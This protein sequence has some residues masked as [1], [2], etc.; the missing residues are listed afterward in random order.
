MDQNISKV[1][2]I[3]E[4]ENEE[5]ENGFIEKKD[6]KKREKL[7]KTYEKFIKKG[8]LKKEIPKIKNEKKE[9]INNT[10]SMNESCNK[11][12]IS[13]KQE[14]KPKEEKNE[15]EA[16]LKH[17]LSYWKIIN[18]PSKIEKIV[19]EVN[20][21][22][23]KQ[24]NVLLEE[25]IN[26]ESKFQSNI[27]D[28][29]ENIQSIKSFNDENNYLN[30]NKFILTVQNQLTVLIKESK[31]INLREKLF[32]IEISDFTI[33]LNTSTTNDS[34]TNLFGQKNNGTGF[35]NSTINGNIN[36]DLPLNNKTGFENDML[37]QK[38]NMFS[39]TKPADSINFMNN[40]IS[41]LNN[42]A[43]PSFS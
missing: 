24:K 9:N 38:T 41:N 18:R 1:E 3:N 10:T 19:N 37:L 15:N 12:N 31:E 16:K 7:S 4:S 35:F 43:T 25:L 21:N 27:V 22:I 8:S 11:G 32:N 28:M 42:N 5:E 13:I 29:K 40:N 34:N 36:K 17:Y 30:I 23:V 26:E 33:L 39:N 14:E 6:K 2:V 20:E